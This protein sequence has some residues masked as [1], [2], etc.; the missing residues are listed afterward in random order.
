MDYR[1]E[2]LSQRS[3]SDLS[4]DALLEKDDYHISSPRKT[5][6]QQGPLLLLHGILITIYTA[7]CFTVVWNANTQISEYKSCQIDTPA[8]S[9]LQ[10]VKLR[11]DHHT[12]ETEKYFGPPSEKL[13]NA[14]KEILDYQSFKFSKEEMTRYGRAHEGVELS[15]GTGYMGR[16]LRILQSLRLL[17]N[18]ESATHK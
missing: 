16:I 4:K 8:R 2:P 11:F 3:S 15:D 14:W 6:G 13:D 9:A 5:W 18:A 17:P 10:E 1:H 7:I 12:S